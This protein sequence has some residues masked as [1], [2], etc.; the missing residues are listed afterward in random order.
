MI[1][2]VCGLCFVLCVSEVLGEAGPR[3]CF[4]SERCRSTRLQ[5][6]ENN[7][8]LR[9][10]PDLP[11]ARCQV[12]VCS[13]GGVWSLSVSFEFV[14]SEKP[15]CIHLPSALTLF[16]STASQHQLPP[17]APPRE[18]SASWSITSYFKSLSDPP[19]LYDNRHSFK[20]TQFCFFFVFIWF[21]DHKEI[22]II[23]W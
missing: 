2:T 10:Y 4:W 17:P 15:S 16:F 3:L 13:S 14:Y 20:W 7:Q 9:L 23:R 21:V 8:H 1:W 5:H 11:S 18:P 12:I 19:V 6:I 22:K